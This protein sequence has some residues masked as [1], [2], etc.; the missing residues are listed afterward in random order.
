MSNEIPLKL[1]QTRKSILFK[2][3]GK[4]RFE[5][6]SLYNLRRKSLEPVITKKSIYSHSIDLPAWAARPGL[7]LISRFGQTAP[8]IME[9]I[10]C[11]SV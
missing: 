2:T 8:R 7:K 5:E 11:N 1:L 9:P 6:N 3:K 10:D 4:I